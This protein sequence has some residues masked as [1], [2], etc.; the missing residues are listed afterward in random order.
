MTEK[1]KTQH[2][3]CKNKGLKYWLRW[4]AVLPGA[5]L[6]GILASF[7]L[8]WILYLTLRNE[9]I[10]IDPYPELPE[11]L[12]SP[13]V[14]ATVFIWTGSR[15]A[16]E[17]KFKTSVVLFGLCLFLLG[18]FIFFALTGA[19][20]MGYQL[21]FQDGGIRLI[22]AFAGALTGLFLSG[23]ISLVGGINKKR[24]S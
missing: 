16:P 3:M 7:L 11:R 18:G 4:L 9:T 20:L 21:Y 14:M 24:R 8:H 2:E 12:L 13:F 5:L 23:G 15:I 10:F 22:M 6:A 1:F 17:H 19:N